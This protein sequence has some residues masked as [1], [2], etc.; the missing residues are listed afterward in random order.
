MTFEI[1]CGDTKEPLMVQLS[2]ENGYVD[3]SDCKI[4]FIMSDWRQKNILN[5]GQAEVKDALN[6]ICWYVF[7]DGETNADGTFKGEF[8]VEYSDFKKETFS[9]E[10][11]ITILIN[12]NLG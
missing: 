4:R 11:Y 9:N 10:G 3:L 5:D 7:E 12:K 1:K 2:D 6:G 8:K